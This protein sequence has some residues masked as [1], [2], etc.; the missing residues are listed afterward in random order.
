[1]KNKFDRDKWVTCKSLLNDVK[2]MSK[3]NADGGYTDCIAKEK[4]IYKLMSKE[5]LIAA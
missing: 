3:E 5:F 1:M 4:A 2:I